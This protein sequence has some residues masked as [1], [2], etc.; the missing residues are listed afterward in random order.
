[1]EALMRRRGGTVAVPLSG[2]AVRAPC[3]SPG[4]NRL[5]PGNPSYPSVVALLRLLA[6]VRL[7][8]LPL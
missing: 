1:M 7:R 6:C 5:W 2:S 8:C 4:A 3:W